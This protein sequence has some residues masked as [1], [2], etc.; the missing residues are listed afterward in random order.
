[1]KIRKILVLVVLTVGF[2][3]AVNAQKTVILGGSSNVSGQKYC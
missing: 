3:S 1:M 2:G